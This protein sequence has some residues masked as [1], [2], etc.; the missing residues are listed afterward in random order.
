M[1]LELP[2]SFLSIPCFDDLVARVNVP[3]LVDRSKRGIADLDE[4][5]NVFSIQVKEAMSSILKAL[6]RN[7][8]VNERG[9]QILIQ[10]LALKI[11]DEKRN[12]KN[13]E[14]KLRF[15][16][17]EDEKDFSGL[18][19]TSIQNF[20]VRMKTIY[21]EAESYY[22]EILREV[23]INWKNEK[24]VRAVIA[25]VENFQ[26]Y[27]FVRSQNND[28]YQLVFYNFA[29]RFQKVDK[30]QYLTPQPLIDFLVKIVNPRGNESVCDPCVGIADFLSMAYVNAKRIGKELDDANLWGVDID[31]YMIMLAELNMLL[32]GDGK[33]HLLKATSDH[34]SITQKISKDG[35]RELVQLI[36]SLHKNGNWDN[37][38]DNTQLRKFNVVLTNPPFGKGRSF[39]VKTERDRQIV[40]MYET[41][42]T[43]KEST[44]NKQSGKGA[45][46]KGILFIENAYQIL[47]RNG[48]IGIVT[49]NSIASID[50]W[51]AVRVNWLMERMRIVAIFDLPPEVFAETGVNTTLIVAYK[52]S[53]EEL[54]R[55]KSQ[56]YSVFIREIKK[57]G[58]EKK[59]HKRNVTFEPLFKID[60]VTFE[61]VTDKDGGP[62]LDEEFSKFVNEFR[63][64]ALTQEETLQKIFIR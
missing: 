33:T 8:L 61:I 26:D 13:Q 62:V 54:E 46:D 23:A 50:Q 3:S 36:P 40:E 52:P 64:W 44:K 55:L 59:T 19:E 58:Y 37:W 16:I 53:S 2:D 15:Y 27:S 57:V 41:W 17:N 30:A 1:S 48:R 14:I 7:N 39:E 47:D 5:A 60:P 10:T 34:G 24:H 18:H 11:F 21:D 32:N 45:M 6:D 29:R 63:E 51:K 56:N 31:E 12:E 22:K 28:L 35:E 25:I 4:I 20:L 9:Y 42:N 49:S 38:K 43:D